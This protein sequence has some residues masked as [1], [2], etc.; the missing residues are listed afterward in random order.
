MNSDIK[1]G[2][3]CF[4]LGCYCMQHEIILADMRHWETKMN[5]ISFF[6]GFCMVMCFASQIFTSFVSQRRTADTH[7]K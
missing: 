7:T 6:F 1:H 2:I 3:M 5:F 4:A